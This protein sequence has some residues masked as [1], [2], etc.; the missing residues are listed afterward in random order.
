MTALSPVS[1][2]R[3]YTVPVL[4]DRESTSIAEDDDYFYDLIPMAFNHRLVMTPKK[5]TRVWDYGWCY[6][7][8]LAAIACVHVW[9]PETQNE[10]LGWKKRPTGEVVRTAPRADADPQYNRPRCLHGN[11]PS[12]GPCRTD[13]YCGK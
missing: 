2:L 5:N 13:P 12:D 3:L 6:D 1:A 8:A 10:P 4:N 9:N 11:Y 7:S